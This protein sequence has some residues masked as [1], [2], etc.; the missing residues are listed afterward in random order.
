MNVKRCIALLACGFSIAAFAASPV[1]IR[2]VETDELPV[3]VYQN[4]DGD[5]TI[6]TE[7]LTL[8]QGEGAPW[9]RVAV[10]YET[11]PEWIDQLTLEFYVLF[12]DTEGQQMVFKGSVDYVDIPQARDHLA[13]MYLHANSYQRYGTRRPSKISVVAKMDGKI[14]AMDRRTAKDT[15]WWE[16]L[17][18]HPAGLLN[19]LDTPFRAVNAGAYEAQLIA[20]RTAN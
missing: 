16:G 15:Q 20:P 5:D 7:V 8:S 10:Q 2:E 18:T 13:E 9:F 19:R 4:E 17:P 14:V 1:T 11:E 6:Q 12:D 3:P